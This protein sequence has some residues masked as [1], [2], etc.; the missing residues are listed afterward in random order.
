MN[1]YCFKK[2]TTPFVALSSYIYLIKFIHEKRL[3]PD[4]ICPNYK[5]KLNL[6]LGEK[7]IFQSMNL[8]IL[9]ILIINYAA[10]QV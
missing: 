7:S 8:L 9:K 2:N 3:L 5:E 1:L 6:N 4:K 10:I